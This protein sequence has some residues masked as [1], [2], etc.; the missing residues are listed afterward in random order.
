MSLL[1]VLILWWTLIVAIV[2]FDYLLY[3][4]GCSCL[5]PKD[6]HLHMRLLRLSVRQ[7]IWIIAI[8]CKNCAAIF[9]RILSYCGGKTGAT[10]ILPIFWYVGLVQLLGEK[11]K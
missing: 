10:R 7:F 4:S 1:F 2:C 8:V 11:M 9:V 6:E 5:T 3:A